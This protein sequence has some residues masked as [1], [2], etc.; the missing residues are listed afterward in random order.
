M[1]TI[2]TESQMYWLTRMNYICGFEYALGILLLI[3]SLVFLINF[4][5]ARYEEVEKG[6]KKFNKWI[7]SSVM[8]VVLSI[9]TILGAVLTPST[10][11]MAAIKVVPLIVNDEK[12]RELPNKVV[13]LANEWLDQL[14]PGNIDKT[15]T[16]GN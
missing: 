2:V 4:S 5:Y 11:E 7:F 6:K 14:K 3:V 9:L 12:V 15:E 13:D 16:K 1:N 10:K 8:G